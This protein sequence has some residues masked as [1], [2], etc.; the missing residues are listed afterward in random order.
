MP[1]FIALDCLEVIEKFLWD[2]EGGRVG[3]L[4]SFPYHLK[5]TPI[6][7]WVKLRLGWVVTI[8]N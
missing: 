3:G 7:S 8:S 4:G 1:S 2:G 5:V 6:R